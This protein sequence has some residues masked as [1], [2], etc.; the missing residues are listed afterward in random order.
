MRQ[1]HRAGEKAFLDYSGKKPKIV[2]A[3]TGEVSAAVQRSFTTRL[4]SALVRDAAG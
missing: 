2:D 4:F 1:T 3:A